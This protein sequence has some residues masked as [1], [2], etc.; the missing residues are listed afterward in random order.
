MLAVCMLLKIKGEFMSK[1]IWQRE[2]DD[3][4]AYLDRHGYRTEQ[5]NDHILVKDE[6]LFKTKK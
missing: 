6:C 5:K 2:A 1:N 4:R 3:I